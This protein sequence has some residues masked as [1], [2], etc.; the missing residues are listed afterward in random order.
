[1]SISTARFTF[2][3][4][5]VDDLEKPAAFYKSVLGMREMFR[6]SDFVTP[7]MPIEEIMLSLSGD[8]QA[9]PPLVLFKFIGKPAP[10]GSDCILGFTVP[11]VD[12]VVARAV[13]AGGKVV[14]APK[15]QPEHGV[16]VAFV[17]DLDGRLLEIVQMLVPAA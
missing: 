12:A 1:M 13:A 5:I 15:D 2:T 17:T 7:E 6:V 3:K 4:I 9:E 16:R 10:K 14:R 8:M 11:D